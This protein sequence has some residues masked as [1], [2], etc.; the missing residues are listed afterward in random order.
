MWIYAGSDG[1]LVRVCKTEDEFMRYG[2]P[3][4]YTESLEVDPDTNSLIG[5]RIDVASNDVRLSG[6][7]LSYKGQALTVNPP[8]AEWVA[9]TDADDAKERILAAIDTALADYA[10]ALAAWAT[11]TVPQQKAVLRRLVEVQVQLL[12]YHRRELL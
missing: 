9:R 11:L 7:I 12:R 5:S 10:N 3:V 6:G 1:R 2:P 4:A 8:S